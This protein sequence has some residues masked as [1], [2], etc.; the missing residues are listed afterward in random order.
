MNNVYSMLNNKKILVTGSTGMIGQNIVKKIQELN[1]QENAN[2]RIV[3]HARDEERY[4][5]AFGKSFESIICDI[6]EL[7]YKGDID[8]IIHTASITGGS[9]KHLD[10]PLKTLFT[11]IEGTRKV[12]ELALNCNCK[13]VVF[14]SS[15]EVYG[16]R[17][18]PSEKIKEDTG[19]YFDPM[20]PRSS[21]SEGKRICET[22]LA[23]YHKQYGLNTISARLA[24]TFGYGVSKDDERVFA[25]FARSIIDG[26]D[27]VLKSKGETVRNYCDAQDC[28][29]ALLLLLCQGE[30]G[31]AF[32]VVNM[33]N[34]IS[35]KDL[36]QKFIDL[37]PESGSSLTMDLKDDPVKLGYNPTIHCVL[38]SEKLMNLGWKPKY[39]IDDMIVHLVE[40]MKGQ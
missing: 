20:N 36:A 19:G 37:Y 27:I 15:I 31:Q 1:E 12:L 4:K 7:N 16:N 14:T 40:Y 23:S 21:Y 25:Q 18:L 33:D 11:S 8:F 6:T 32:N 24:P 26:R 17:N 38:N 29:D 9:K 28:A 34:E 35:I 30:T 3:A 10:N 22:L 13:K 2:I 5:K 39:S